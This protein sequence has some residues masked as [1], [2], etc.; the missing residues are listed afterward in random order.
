V[1]HASVVA[2]YAADGGTGSASR[3]SEDIGSG[4]LWE[5]WVTA[6]ADEAEADDVDA[7][8]GAGEPN[9]GDQIAVAR[10]AAAGVAVEL[11]EESADHCDRAVATEGAGDKGTDGEKRAPAFTRGA[12]SN[13][14]RTGESSGRGA[15]EGGWGKRPG[16][17]LRRSAANECGCE[18]PP[19]SEAALA[20]AAA[21]A[22]S[23]RT[24]PLPRAD[25]INS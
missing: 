23:D 4:L 18:G 16:C 14:E 17:L 3:R 12:A 10:A 13:D 8:P 24:A 11:A 21:N 7:E 9:C 6:D 2:P 22:S 1:V 25:T 5:D 19:A 20:P 15:A